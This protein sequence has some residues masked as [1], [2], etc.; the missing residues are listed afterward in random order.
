MG[1][2]EKI[3]H[4]VVLMQE[5]RSFDCMLGQLYPKS[6]EFNGLS[7]HE[8]NPLQGQPNVSVWSSEG[9]DPKSMCLPNPDPGESWDDVNMALFGLD[10]TPGDQVPPM[11]GFVNNYMQTAAAKKDPDRYQPNMPMHGFVA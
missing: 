9:T 11:N 4:I 6:R 3:E 10:G 8:T 1:N 7:G 5:N 2:L